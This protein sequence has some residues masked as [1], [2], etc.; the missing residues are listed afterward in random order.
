MSTIATQLAPFLDAVAAKTS[1]PGGGAVA[2]ASG[3]LACSMARM[4]ALYSS[5]DSDDGEVTA[6][7][8]QLERADHLLRRLADEDATA[9][10]ALTEAMKK[11]KADP[12]AQDEY[13]LAVGVAA[14][15]PMEIA[16]VAGQSLE[17]MARLVPVASKYM[18]SDLGVAA[19]LA[20]SA[21][22]SAGYMV[23]ANTVIMGS[24]DA[25]SD[26]EQAFDTLSAKAAERLKTIQ[27]ALSGPA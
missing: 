9:Y 25:R 23:R 26:T 8:E 11:R 16:A 4:V 2:A 22:R 13:D 17:L 18:L 27:A 3:A 6:L 12:S 7:P 1:T 15:V 24:A 19:V 10:L 5:G 20:E 21:V 14:A